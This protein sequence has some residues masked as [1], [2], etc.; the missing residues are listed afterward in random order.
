MNTKLGRVEKRRFRL[1]LTTLAFATASLGI[2][3]ALIVIRVLSVSFHLDDPAYLHPFKTFVAILMVASVLWVLLIHLLRRGLTLSKA[4]IGILVFL[5]TIYRL[6]FISS[7]PIYENDYH[8]YLWDGAVTLSGIN[9][10]AYSPKQTFKIRSD[11]PDEIRQLRELTDK[12]GQTVELIGYPELTTIYPPGAIVVFSMAAAI[13]PFNLDVLRVV[14]LVFDALALWILFKCLRLF[15]RSISWA[16]IYWLN[17]LAIFS[18]YNAAH[19]DVILIAPIIGAI[20]FAKARPMIAACL[21]GVA[22]SIKFWPLVLA[23]IIFRHLLNDPKRYV[24]L[25]L[26]SGFV[27]LGFVAPMFLSMEENSGLLAY[28]TQWNKNSFLFSILENKLGLLTASAGKISRSIVFGVILSLNI[29]F[30]FSRAMQRRG[31]HLSILLICLTLLFLAPAGYPWY[32]I[33]LLPFICFVPI[34]GAAMLSV[35]LPLYYLRYA[36]DE[37]GY[38]WAFNNVIVPIEF[39]IPLLLI[40]LEYFVR[41]SGRKQKV[42]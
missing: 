39:G 19:M 26:I 34:Y 15:N 6:A 22:A 11:T 13:D 12:N 3:I 9:P 16:L 20:F 8:R 18:T 35:C 42:I 17:P 28:A 37:L 23:P 5:G 36:M 24:F 21:I 31:L 41:L 29:W 14:F 10:Y 2:G 27:F 7:P 25:G 1:P 4:M 32:F 38:S 40:F 33:W 30:V